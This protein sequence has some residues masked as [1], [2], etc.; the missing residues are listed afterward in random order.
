MTDLEAIKKALEGD[1]NTGLTAIDRLRFIVGGVPDF[2]P[3]TVE[4]ADWIIA[5]LESL[6]SENEELRFN[7]CATTSPQH[8]QSRRARHG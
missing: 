8:P 3:I 4:D 1:M 6:Q 7:T 5:A 2:D